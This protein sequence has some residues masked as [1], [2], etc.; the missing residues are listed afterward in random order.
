MVMVNTMYL[1]HAEA[2]FATPEMWRRWRINL[3]GKYIYE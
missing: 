1:P 2:E 3:L